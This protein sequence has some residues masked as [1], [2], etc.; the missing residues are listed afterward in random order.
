MATLRSE[1]FPGVG[2]F[3]DLV[4]GDTSRYFTNRNHI[5]WHNIVAHTDSRFDRLHLVIT[6]EQFFFNF[7]Q[8]RAKM[9]RKRRGGSVE[10][11][12]CKTVNGNILSEFIP[13]LYR[14]S[15]LTL[16]S[17]IIICSTLVRYL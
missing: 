1:Y 15:F 9:K 2:L 7:F 17:I 13:S 8:Y 4:D 6:N 14:V 10:F 16:V 3:Y 12:L 11:F 5:N